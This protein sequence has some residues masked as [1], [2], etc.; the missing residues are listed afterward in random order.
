MSKHALSIKSIILLLILFLGFAGATYAWFTDSVT[1]EGN[2]IQAGNLKVKFEVS[3][4]LKGIYHDISGF[5][6]PVFDFGT[7]AEP[8]DNSLVSYIKVTNAGSISL[9]YQIDF[10]ILEND[11]EDVVFFEIEKV[12]WVGTSNNY[13]LTLIDGFALANEKLEGFN[14]ITGGF[15]VY[16]V[17]MTFDADNEY[18]LDDLTDPLKFIFDIRLYGY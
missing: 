10:I 5:G 17:T 16:K 12:A 7:N 15:E 14:L 11:L 2:R 3:D 1:N 4:T 8:G 9:S 18:N 6:T 13:V